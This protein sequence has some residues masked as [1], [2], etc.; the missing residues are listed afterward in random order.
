MPITTI[1]FPYYL[2]D[3][4]STSFA[5]SSDSV[6]ASFAFSSDSE[7]ASFASSTLLEAGVSFTTS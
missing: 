3:S 5:S 7:S 6:S 2:S 4:V 1:T